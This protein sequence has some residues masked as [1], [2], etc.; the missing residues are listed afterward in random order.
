MKVLKF[1]KLD[2][3][4]TR[5]FLWTLLYPVFVIFILVNDDEPSASFAVIYC[6]FVGIV[7]AGMPFFSTEKGTDGG[8][9]RMLPAKPGDD[10]RGH[11][12]YAFSIITLS[13]L[14]GL[15]SIW[16]A[17]RIRPD[18][19]IIDYI[20]L[21]GALPLLF[22]T[23]LLISGIDAL[24]MILFRNENVR[25]MKLLRI[26][27]AF[28]FFAGAPLLTDSLRDSIEN[29]EQFMAKSGPIITAFCILA[30]LGLAAIASRISARRDG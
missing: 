6:L 30:F 1:L 11:F 18:A 20:F 26:V 13:A 15:F 22:G 5:A 19:V 28:L 21:R 7:L 3:I 27:P 24:L 8:F 23:A 17:N 10:I 29:I 2:I 9:I 14:L 16:V 4:N 25:V 12:L